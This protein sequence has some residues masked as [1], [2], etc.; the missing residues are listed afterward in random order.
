MKQKII[1]GLIGLSVSGLLGFGLLLILIF[2]PSLL[3]AHKTTILNH[4]IY[5]DGELSPYFEERLNESLSLITTSELYDKELTFD[6]CLDNNSTLPQLMNTIQGPAY[7][8][9]LFNQ[10]VLRGDI[11]YKQNTIAIHGYKWNLS[12]LIAHELT[13]CLQM[14]A[15][16]FWNSNPVANY[17]TWKWE[18]YPEYISRQHLDQL[19]LVSNIE[20]KRQQEL[21]NGQ[22]WA[23]EFKNGTIAPRTYYTSWIM[24]QYCIDIKGITYRELLENKT[25]NYEL[26]E[27]EL[28]V[29]YKTKKHE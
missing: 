16:G 13:H 26:L 24:V 25:L 19:D 12:Q 28:S 15:F 7:G 20:L 21:E 4:N 18:G 17:D 29:W 3:Y 1:K 14:H 8:W 10:V 9:G 11:D 27:S 5:Y 22:A 2:N 23:F 6:I